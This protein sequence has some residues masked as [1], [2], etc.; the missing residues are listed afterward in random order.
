MTIITLVSKV[1]TD[2][3][4]E[5]VVLDAMQCATK[6]YNG[7]IW[8][9]REQYKETGKSPVSRQNLNKIM[10]LLPRRQGYYSL[11]AQATR[12]KLIE[13][14]KSYF[15]LRK[16][17]DEETRPPGFR[18][19][20]SYSNLRYFNGYGFWLKGNELTL[21]LGRK[22]EDGVRY[23]TMQIQHRPKVSYQRVINV[24][25]IYDKK[26]GLQAHLVVDVEEKEALGDR[27]VAVDL[28]ETQIISA[29]FD[30]GE[31]LL[32]SGRGIKSL[33]RYWQK[34]R[35]RVKPP[36][37]GQRRSRRFRQ[38][39]RKEYRQ[40]HHQLHIITSDFVKRCYHAGV[41]RIVIGNLQGIRKNIK[42]GKKINQRLHAWPFAKISEMIF[43]KA[44][45]LGMTVEFINEA[46]TSQT[47]HRCQKVSRS[48]RRTR[49]SYVCECGWR[50]QADVNAAANIFENYTNVS[51]LERSSGAVAAPVVLPLRTNAH[52][53]YAPGCPH[54]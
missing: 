10:K 46:Y 34:I 12:D 3:S 11:S 16:N 45:M 30:D 2:E 52:T 15:Q 21:S 5:A 49:G 29:M 7:L 48:N 18:R 6:V 19:K 44:Q 36:V 38:I 54:L 26:H 42:Y 47:C 50:V 33:R 9:L 39:E 4:T 17:G 1:T 8:H 13:A 40:V 20:N 14:Y 43:Y 27:I 53:V 31:V 37:Q 51:P 22:R 32:Y 35:R 23:V 28:G 24:V 25:M 41:N